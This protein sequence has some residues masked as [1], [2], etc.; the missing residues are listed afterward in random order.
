MSCSY[1]ALYAE[2]QLSREEFDEMLA[3]PLRNYDK[4]RKE[5]DCEDAFP[6]IYEKISRMGRK[7][8]GKS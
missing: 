7:P 3:F 4:L 5:L 2:T 1:V 6:H 8:L